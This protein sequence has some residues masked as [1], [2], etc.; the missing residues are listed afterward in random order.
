MCLAKPRGSEL[1]IRVIGAD[2][3]RVSTRAITVTK[4]NDREYYVKMYDLESYELTF[5]EKIGGKPDS[6]IKLK[7]V[8]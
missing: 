6:Y 3:V 7:D 8:E 5:E 1:L 2:A 4:R